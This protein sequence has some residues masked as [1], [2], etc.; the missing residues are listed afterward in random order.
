L[1]KVVLDTNVLISA[2]LFGGNPRKILHHVIRGNVK[3]CI[4][5]QII[6]ELKRVLKRPK[7]GFSPEIIQL[8][9]NELIM[10]SEFIIPR[11]KIDVIQVDP[12]DNKILECAAEAG[13]NYIITGDIHL[14]ELQ[15][16]KE[17]KIVNPAKF[18]EE[19]ST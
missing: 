13:A 3:L 9:V 2:V 12:E 18:I 17:I 5:E 14:L 15:S 4:S 8:I 19:V 11:I 10:L 7:F 16:F 6:D 1:L